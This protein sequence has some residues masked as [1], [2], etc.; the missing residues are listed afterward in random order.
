M[1]IKPQV[2]HEVITPEKAKEY[3]EAMTGN[4]TESNSVVSRYAQAMADGRWEYNNGD[5]ISFNG[6]GLIDGQH[7]LSACI[8]SGVPLE[9]LVVRGVSDKAFMRKDLGK[10]RSNS[11][12]LSCVNY[13]NCNALAPAA[14]IVYTYDHK[15]K[16][17]TYPRIDNEDILDTV[18]S[19]PDLEYWVTRVKSYSRKLMVPP[20]PLAG[21]MT[22]F[23]RSNTSK[24]ESFLHKLATGERLS[25]GDPILVLRSSLECKLKKSGAG[26]FVGYAGKRYLA[27]VLILTWNNYVMGKSK[28]NLTVPRK[29]KLLK[30]K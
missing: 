28:T 7:R 24:A 27:E 4:R 18:E 3:L 25:A 1:A 2:E 6:T 29:E 9:I 22:L 16:F 26:P 30:I 13:K 23:S 10:V 11:D 20:G 15:I 8:R 21:F 19:N 5:T 14:K 17:G 12:A